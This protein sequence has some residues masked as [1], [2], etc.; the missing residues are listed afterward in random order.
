MAQNIILAAFGIMTLGILVFMALIIRQVVCS[1]GISHHC[2][3]IAWGVIFV[4]L[5]SLGGSWA[6]VY[7]FFFP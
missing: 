1:V 4:A 5:L 3:P 2:L 6:F 7:F